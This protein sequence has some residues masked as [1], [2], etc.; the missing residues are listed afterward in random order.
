[1]HPFWG[2]RC[3]GVRESDLGYWELHVVNRITTACI[4]F[5]ELFPVKGTEGP[6]GFAFN[7]SLWFIKAVLQ[8]FASNFAHCQPVWTQRP[9]DSYVMNHKSEI[10]R[11]FQI[12][13][14]NGAALVSAVLGPDTDA[15]LLTRRKEFHTL[16]AG[17]CLTHPENAL[18]TAARWFYRKVRAR[19]CASVPVFGIETTMQP[20]VL[21]NL[22]VEKLG[23]VFVEIL[24]FDRVMSHHALSCLQSRQFL[25]AFCCDQK[26]EDQ[27]GIDQW[28]SIS[29]AHPE[30][31]HAGVIAILDTVVQ[32]NA[33][34]SA[35][36]RARALDGQKQTAPVR[37]DRDSEI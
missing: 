10:E 8:K 17:H 5:G 13:W 9:R 7:S 20:E 11:E 22:L 4:D 24:V 23:H 34:W 21:Q 33:R 26:R 2:P 31:L 32:Y 29:A 30:E 16:M 15:N 36:Y 19:S 6:H 37:P 3:I 1:M 25:I 28:I 12:R 27:K 18:Q 35:Q 14:R